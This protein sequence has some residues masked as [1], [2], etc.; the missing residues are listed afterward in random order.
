[1]QERGS[2][3]VSD[4]VPACVLLR[5]HMIQ[6]VLLCVWGGVLWVSE[7]RPLCDQLCVCR[8]KHQERVQEMR[9]TTL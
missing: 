3:T 1:M 5:G 9:P 6:G 8:P 2:G 7:W 4:F